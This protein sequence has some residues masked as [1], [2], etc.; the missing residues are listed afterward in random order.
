MLSARHS[1]PPCHGIGADDRC[2][3]IGRP[4][5]AGLHR[6]AEGRCFTRDLVGQFA[7][8]EL[9]GPLDE[10]GS[11]ENHR[12]AAAR[13]QSV[14]WLVAYGRGA[15]LLDPVVKPPYAILDAS[16]GFGPS[17]HL[18]GPGDQVVAPG[19]DGLGLRVE[20]TGLVGAIDLDCPLDSTTY[21][22]HRLRDRIGMVVQGMAKSLE[23]SVEGRQ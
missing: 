15:D 5:P 19:A 23:S 9:A 7:E 22:L 20:L 6:E 1:C 17:L 4:G 8:V 18:P 13:Q 21:P 2:E 16:V 10:K 11:V 3:V 14:L 12:L